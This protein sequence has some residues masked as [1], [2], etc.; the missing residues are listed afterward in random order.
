MN[1]YGAIAG[2]YDKLNAD[3][4]Y[5]S[6]ADGVEKAF[7]I[8]LN[9]KPEIV[10]D[11]ACGTGRMTYEL[12]HKGYDMIGVDISADM[13]MHARDLQNGESILWLMQDM[14]SFELYGTVGA[15]V[16][17]LDA[18]NCMMNAKDLERCFATVHNYLDPDGLF[19]FDINSPYKFERIF[20]DNA[21][22]LEDNGVYCGWQNEYDNERKTCSFYLTVFEER[23]DGSYARY[24]ETQREKCYSE[25]QIR[26]VLEKCRFEVLGVFG[27]YDMTPISENTERYYFAARA[28][29]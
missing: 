23:E 2:V 7:E 12:S 5:S 22:I 13:L 10:L 11:L 29:K 14:R 25:K 26:T 9:K 16:C 3:I 8:Y 1:G 24:D 19:L 21:Y 20:S 4:D 6:W 18:V 28:K 17:C 15:T 27:G